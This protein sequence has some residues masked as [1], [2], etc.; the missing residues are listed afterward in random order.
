[1]PSEWFNGE[2]RKAQCRGWRN[3]TRLERKEIKRY[4]DKGSTLV[5]PAI[6]ETEI[7]PSMFGLGGE[8]FT[9]DQDV[10][11]VGGDL[12]DNPD[13]LARKET[14]GSEYDLFIT[15]LSGMVFTLEVV[16]TSDSSV[17]GTQS[18]DAIVPALS[19][20]QFC[21]ATFKNKTRI[22]FNPCMFEQAMIDF[23]DMIGNFRGYT[24]RYEFDSLYKYIITYQPLFVPFLDYDDP[25]MPN[26][27]GAYE[28]SI[29][30][31]YAMYPQIGCAVNTTKPGEFWVAM[32]VHPT[33]NLISAT[34]PIGI[35]YQKFTIT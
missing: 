20:P 29:S 5:I 10:V 9:D 22:A 14:D 11:L 35:Y 27:S 15:P 33:P 19:P 32:V 3:A 23:P 18:F 8:H 21:G 26:T 16:S 13:I 28:A 6:F 30:S 4:C 31:D 1:M 2:L 17:L 7:T 12:Y 25:S 24:G 34:T